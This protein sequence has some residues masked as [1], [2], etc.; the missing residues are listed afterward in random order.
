[1]N[2]RVV[3]TGVGLVSPLGCST[4]T[5]WQS[6]LSCKS[7][8]T[9]IDYFDV[10]EYPAKIAGVLPKDE[11]TPD[12][13]MTQSEQ[14]RVD[15][16]IVYAV[17][18]AA[19]AY[20]DAGFAFL[21]EEQRAKTVVTVGSG[22]GGVKNLY[23]TSVTLHND[24]PRRVSPFFI[25][26]VLINLASGH[27]AIKYGL[28]GLNYGV[29]SACAS[30]THSIGEAYEMIKLGRADF[31]IAGGAEYAVCE[32]GI[33]G[34]GAAKA[35]S[36]RYN[37]DPTS[38]SRPW[39]VDRDGFVVGEGAGV[40]CMETYESAVSRGAKIYG[41]IVGYGAS[42]DAYHIT[43]P[44]VSGK[45]AA[46]AMQNALND[47]KLAPEDVNYIN[48][49]GTSTMPGD[50]A[51][52][53]AIKNVFGAHAYNI[54]VSSTKSAMGHLLGAAGAVESIVCLLAMQNSV[55]PATLN[56][57][58]PSPECDI[59]LTP[60]VPQ[61]RRINVAMNNSFGFGGTNACLIFKKL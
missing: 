19:Q 22:I 25:P 41:E 26:S 45:G 38:A 51:E 18:A 37:N 3:V 6:L 21:D 16:F 2:R 12:L 43:A 24:G 20:D 11:Y 23:T 31:A 59:N 60:L 33:S 29:V 58:K 14:R 1:M 7:G 46:A 9:Y 10:S 32:L 50:I 52:V 27:I 42:C 55:C 34:F 35:L 8:I 44:L 49:H 4:K 15:Q 30:G 13:Y 28:T 39:D 17:V 54:N 61:E 5:L 40:L 57:H 56:L 53:V 36:T 47:A 48:A